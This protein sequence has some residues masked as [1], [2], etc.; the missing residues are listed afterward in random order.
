MTSKNWAQN[1]SELISAAWKA[2]A[3]ED[4]LLMTQGIIYGRNYGHK[5]LRLEVSEPRACYVFSDNYG[6][7]FYH[8][9][10]SCDEE[11]TWDTKWDRAA[12]ASVVVRFIINT[13]LDKELK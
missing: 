5:Y 11:I 10:S 8:S 2:T 9:T 13:L 3:N 4:Q 1:M 6:T 12:E 7:Y